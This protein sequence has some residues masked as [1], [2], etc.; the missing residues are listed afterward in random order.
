MRCSQLR[1]GIRK[2]SFYEGFKLK[3][4]VIPYPSLTVAERIDLVLSVGATPPLLFE[5]RQR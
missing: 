4:H 5:R 3:F 1:N 2:L